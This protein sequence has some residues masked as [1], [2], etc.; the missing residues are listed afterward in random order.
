VIG[1]PA[2]L[3]PY[4]FILTSASFATR[5]VHDD[6]AVAEKGQ[7]FLVLN[8]TVQNPGKAAVRLGTGAIKFTVVSAD[9]ENHE[10]A[11]ELLNPETM[12]LI[13][14]EV[15]PA[16]KVP[17]VAYVAVPAGDPIPKLIVSSGEAPVL[18]FDLKGKVKKFIGMFAAPDGVTAL[19]IGKAK[20]GEKI[21]LGH[22]DITVEK[23]EESPTAIGEM[24][25]PEGQKV[26]ILTVAYS[27]STKVTRA[28]DSASYV[29]SMKD[30]NDETIE[31]RETLLRAVGNTALTENIKP[32]ETKRGRLIFAAA[33]EATPANVTFGWGEGRAVLVSLK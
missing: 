19:D 32:G 6:T 26:V 30:A 29:L 11:D 28:I 2:R 4:Q 22:L 27:N 7:K 14:I 17:V 18:R 13:E 12:R 23:I 5:V 1:T 21:E 9:N 20:I 8:F 33:K 31:Y 15:K 3:G 24:D 16:Q 25:L 10:S